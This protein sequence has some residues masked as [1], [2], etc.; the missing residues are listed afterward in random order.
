MPNQ[1]T[2]LL[3]DD[4]ADWRMV[5]GEALLTELPDAHIIEAASGREAL[6][7]L[8]NVDQTRPELI[9]TDLDMPG[10]S[11]MDML[12]SINTNRVLRSIPVVVI[13]G[14]DDVLTR[15]EAICNGASG[16]ATKT[17]DP[18]SLVINVL[19]PVICSSWQEEL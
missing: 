10:M 5:L 16:F 2:I 13:T 18:K 19:C 7:L 15:D 12:R 3:V 8:E 14:K 6:D 11:G 9:C 1:F 4:D 17:S